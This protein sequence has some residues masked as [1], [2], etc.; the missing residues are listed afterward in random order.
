MVPE[1]VA[2]YNS[3]LYPVMTCE[4]LV[5]TG[6]WRRVQLVRIRIL[7]RGDTSTVTRP[8]SINITRYTRYDHMTS[9]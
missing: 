2:V 9:K 8:H 5:E 4:H 7:V 3:V 6:H 1:T